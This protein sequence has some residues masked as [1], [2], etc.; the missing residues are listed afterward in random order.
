MKRR[1]FLQLFQ[2]LTALACGYLIV[3]G[4]CF[5]YERPTGWLD[6]YNG[7]SMA[8][9]NPG[10]LLVRGSEGYG[11]H[12]IDENGYMRMVR[13]LKGSESLGFGG[14]KVEGR[15]GAAG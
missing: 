9:R 13:E 15:E 3:N 11:I 5:F 4:L 10:S 2:W 1:L 14:S 8:V 7:P 6:T 12:K